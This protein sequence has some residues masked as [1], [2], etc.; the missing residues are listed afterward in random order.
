[1]LS[2]KQKAIGKYWS[3]QTASKTTDAVKWIRFWQIPRIVADINH[4]ICGE[5]VDG[6]SKG[7]IDRVRRDTG[8]A[9]FE[10]AISIGC[11]G[12][13][14]EAQIL[15]EGMAADFDLYELSESR[16]E[17]G[18]A[19]ARKLGIENRMHF[20]CADAFVELQDARECYD[21]IYWGDS[22]HHMFD[23]D[24]ALAFCKR[25]L[26]PGGVLMLQEYVGPNHLQFTPRMLEIATGVRNLLPDRYLKHPTEPEKALPRRV[27]PTNLK[28][29]LKR[30]P[31]EAADSENILPALRKHFPNATVVP[32]GGV[33]YFVA[34]SD[35]LG[36][37]DM[38][39]DAALLDTLL[40]LDE[41]VTEQ[42]EFLY[43]AA[44]AVQE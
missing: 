4:R 19:R 40:S 11:G 18:K 39:E 2:D 7:L 16:I 22:L 32:L 17:I 26:K 36:N 14:K 3:K 24:D 9:V 34:L 35:V 43:A 1:M 44:Y 13:I 27:I 5:F 20:H 31:S 23:V 29:L 38:Q 37:M 12:G 6:P 30:D 33:I 25:L 21:M 15:T 8:R 42:G 10:R 41:W 28:G